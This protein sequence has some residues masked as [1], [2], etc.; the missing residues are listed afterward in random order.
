MHKFELT[1]RGY[2]LT[3]AEILYHM[4]DHPAVAALRAE[5]AAGAVI[6]AHNQVLREWLRRGGCGPS[7]DAL[8]EAFDYVIATFERTGRKAPVRAR[9]R[10]AVVVV[11]KTS[12]PAESVAERIRRLL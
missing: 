2:R 8:S 7:F 3:T 1:L 10:D 11:V 6:A 12:E 4:P 5:V 9:E